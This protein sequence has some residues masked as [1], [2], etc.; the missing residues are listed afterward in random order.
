MPPFYDGDHVSERMASVR[1]S[2]DYI[3]RHWDQYDS[4]MQLLQHLLRNKMEDFKVNEPEL[5]GHMKS[6]FSI[7]NEWREKGSEVGDDPFDAIRVYTSPLG[8]QSFFSVING[9][10]RKDDSTQRDDIIRAAVFL[11]ELLNI[12]LYNYCL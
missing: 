5:L 8:Y 12:D 10:F 2:I 1:K 9:L 11:M 4:F 3:R 6:L 7:K